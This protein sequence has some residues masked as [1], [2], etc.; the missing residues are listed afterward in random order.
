[1]LFRSTFA[2]WVNNIQALPES[3]ERYLA[4]S[5]REIFDLEGVPIRFLLRKG[6]N[7]YADKEN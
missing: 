4:G 2:L 6:K 3:Y 5:L 1:M 7:P